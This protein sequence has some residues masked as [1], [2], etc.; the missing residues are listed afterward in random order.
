MATTATIYPYDVRQKTGGHYQT[1]TKLNSIKQASGYA[2]STDDIHIKTG[3]KYTPSTVNAYFKVNLPSNAE[4]RKVIIEYKHYVTKSTT[5]RMIPI[6]PAPNVVLNSKINSDARTAYAQFWGK[7]QSPGPSAKN[8]SY[9]FDLS[10]YK[11]I[12][13][14]FFNNGNL[15]IALEYRKNTSNFSGKLHLA[16]IRVKI[17][18]VQPSFDVSMSMV[19]GGYN[20]EEMSL[21]ATI[22]NINLT[23]GDPVVNF[24]LPLGV[25]FV[26]ASGNGTV[27]QPQNR[28][29]TWTPK[30]NR[31]GSVSV[32]IVVLPNVSYP[33]S[34]KTWTGTVEYTMPSFNRSK[35]LNISV[36]ERPPAPDTETDDSE[37]IITDNG[38]SFEYYNLTNDP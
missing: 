4:V 34:D 31:A 35:S 27:T 18:Y 25:S 24:Q 38:N 21:K 26:R 6:L 28:V 11:D 8:E 2:V 23:K 9:T 1:F 5:S 14:S 36:T 3:T 15:H 32:E 22:S 17:E 7:G 29:L 37:N 13:L 16:Y 12:P 19:N 30:V 10:K 33:T 20:R